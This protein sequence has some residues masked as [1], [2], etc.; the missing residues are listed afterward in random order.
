MSWQVLLVFVACFGGG[1]FWISRAPAGWNWQKTVASILA[2]VGIS[3]L[4]VARGFPGHKPGTTSG[5]S[6]A[7][8]PAG[9][10][11]PIGAI[12]AMEKQDL[13]KSYQETAKNVEE[14]KKPEW[15]KE[16]IRKAYEQPTPMEL[17]SRPN[18]DIRRLDKY[19]TVIVFT[20]PG[21]IPIIDT[22]LMAN[23]GAA[24][25]VSTNGK[26]DGIRVGTLKNGSEPD[27][28]KVMPED[29]N[30]REG[31]PLWGNERSAGRTMS[32]IVDAVPNGTYQINIRQSHF[33]LQVGETAPGEFTNKPLV[34]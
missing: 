6:F 32:F 33:A 20:V 31:F 9:E 34:W 4:F 23:P 1:L 26:I 3:I 10:P 14:K 7:N 21:C 18:P 25:F 19:K 13:E 22:E 29:L 15:V 11:A 12:I 17:K 30:R 24:Y 5:E 27:I 2:V 28:K 16:G 8:R